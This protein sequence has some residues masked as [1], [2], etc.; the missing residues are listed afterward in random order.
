M[1]K[2][3]YAGIIICCYLFG[4]SSCL[5]K[6]DL[7]TDTP[8]DE[9]KSSTMY[10]P[11]NVDSTYSVVITQKQNGTTKRDTVKRVA[12]SKPVKSFEQNCITVRRI[13]L[14]Q[15]GIMEKTGNNDGPEIEKFLR[16]VNLN[17][18]LKYAYCSAGVSWT[19]IQAGIRTTITGYSP[20]SVNFKNLVYANHREL[21]KPHFADVVSFYYPYLGR[22]G[23]TGFYDGDF[24]EAIVWTVEFNTSGFSDIVDR[25]GEGVFKKKRSKKTITYISR[26]IPG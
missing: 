6:T 24:N 2:N 3:Y 12:I 10:L 8:P 26:W 14:S 9:A 1:A 5:P 21:K 16:A 17:P 20:S 7:V 11:E 22:I 15:V 4:L 19:F 23:H 13:Y 18:K 25:E